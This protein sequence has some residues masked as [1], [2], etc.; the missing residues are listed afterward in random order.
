MQLSK[1]FLL[2]AV[3]VLA[4]IQTAYA[5]VYSQLHFM[6]V[7]E[8]KDGQD[9]R[10]GEKLKVKYSM[11]PL[12][13]EQTAMGRALKLDINFHRRTGNQKQQQ[14]G[15][16]HKSCPVTAKNDKYVVHTKEWT[17]PKNTKPGSYAVDFVEL[18]Q[19][20]RTQITATETIK[21]NVVD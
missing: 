4:L 5:S 8:P 18:V 9:I 17:I 7:I 19:F 14:I 21:V 2:S 16:I 1:A 11:Q 20:R 10:A 3:L 6:K 13:D 12:I 15:A